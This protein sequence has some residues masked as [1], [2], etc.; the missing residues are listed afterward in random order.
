VA[1]IAK[2]LGHRS[3]HTTNAHYLRMD[4]AELLRQMVIPWEC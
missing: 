3:L 1:S 4:Y 2:F